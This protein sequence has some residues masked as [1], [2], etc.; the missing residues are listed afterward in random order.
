[1]AKRLRGIEPIVPHYPPDNNR[2]AYAPLIW[3]G[4]DTLNA[5]DGP[6]YDAVPDGTTTALD[7]FVNAAVANASTTKAVTVAVTGTLTITWINLGDY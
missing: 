2:G 4:D 3:Y 1:M 5:T 6:W 7:V